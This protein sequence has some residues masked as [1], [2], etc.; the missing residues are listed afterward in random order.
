[1]NVTMTSEPSGSQIY[2]VL[3]IWQANGRQAEQP[4]LKPDISLGRTSDNDIVLNDPRVSARHLRLS[5]SAG[6]AITVMDLGSTNGSLLNGQPL[7]A[8]V[9]CPL[10]PSDTL[11]ISDFYLRVT[12][13]EAA[14]PGRPMAGTRL[15][16][17]G[18]IAPRSET[19]TVPRLESTAAGQPDAITVG[20][21]PDN[22]IVVNHPQVSRYHAL[23]ERMGARYRIKDLKSTNG[24]FVNGKR[25]E[26]EAWLKEGDQ[27]F[28]GAVRLRLAPQGIHRVADEGVRLDAMRLHKW[29]SKSKNLLQDISLS[30]QPHEFVAIVGLSGAGKSML[31]DALNASR[32][33][34]HGTVLVNG[35]NLY[36]NFDMFRSDVGYVPQKD[37]VHTDLTVYRALDYAAQLRMPADTSSA[38]RHQRITQVLQELD[39]TERQDLAIHR[40]SGG[41]L[42]RVSIGVEL[43]TQPHLFFLDEPTSGLDPGTEYNMMRL[44]R[45]LADQGRTILLVTHATKNVMMC[46]KVIIMARG[47]HL[48]FYGPPEEALTYFDQFRTEHERRIK[49]IEFDDIYTIL[50]DEQRGAPADWDKRYQQTTAFN[51]YVV[52]P[53]TALQQGQS[54]PAAA[55]AQQ[56]P[57][58]NMVKQFLVLTRRYLDLVMR[59]RLL[60]FVLLA[61]MPI[62][63]L[64]LVAIAGRT[65]LVGD[66]EAEIERQLMAD[67]SSGSTSATYLLAAKAQRLVF[68][69]SLAGVLL[70][71]FA[72][73]YEIVKESAIYQRER[74]VTLRILPYLASK[75]VVL[76]AFAAIQCFL[77]ML[78]VS[79]KVQFPNQGILLPALVEMYLSLVA[80]TLVAILMG[81]LVSALVP[82]P[83]A[84]IYVLLV[85]LFFQIMFSGV[86]L[87]LP[88][89]TGN[90]SKLTL[91]RWGLEAL[92]V[93][94]N[95]EQANSLTRTRFQLAPITRQVSLKID[96][97]APDWQPVTVVSVT[98]KVDLAVSPGITRTIYL[99]VP[100]VTVNRPV[101]VAQTVTQSITLN[102]DP[103]TIRS[104]AKMLVQ[105]PHTLSYLLFDWAML[106]VFG[107]VFGL[108]A[109]VTLKLKD[110]G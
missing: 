59:D 61:V 16:Q 39:L 96:R 8:R 30:I 11:Q 83:D 47:G 87:D 41:Q 77:L 3:Q 109:I 50:E 60:L 24:V 23:I 6:G 67:L 72:G 33:A 53:I 104:P 69:M 74:M 9:P 57:R 7:P 31:L 18:E 70:G 45:K 81:L 22:T 78:V 29:V 43:L 85:L 40:L 10:H 103:M 80:M 94:A 44:L 36:Q 75:I 63:G 21:A 102:P 54:R 106:M 46:D 95:V 2:G 14:S 88:G 84:V 25:I 76:G 65:W 26:R 93:S 97:P 42:K 56:R 55:L 100:Q 89:M 82:K 108:G 58:V 91:T 15:A 51:Q 4:I 99:S 20:R 73:A 13:P 32:P 110:A 64:F 86:F 34:T 68:M 79:L 49:D 98:Q 62:L 38:E 101:T 71:V 48:A 37:I 12:L 105:Y 1:M 27:I 19:I 107:C 17:A 35:I 90:I 92:G 5:F 52:Q 66:A 28:V